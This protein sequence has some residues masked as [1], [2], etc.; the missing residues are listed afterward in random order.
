[1]ASITEQLEALSSSTP[2]RLRAE[3]RRVFRKDA[4][5]HSPD[6]MIRAIAWRLQSRTHGDLPSLARQRLVRL[7]DQLVRRDGAGLITAPPLA[8]GTRLVRKWNERTIEVIVLESGYL[9][10]DRHF[11]SLS[12]I[13]RHVTG[14]QWS[15]PRFFGLKKSRKLRGDRGHGAR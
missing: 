12:Q 6:L 4:P 2:A 5:P 10:D 13:A 11:T 1:M 15:G 8:P 7:A 3:W 14:T 9:F